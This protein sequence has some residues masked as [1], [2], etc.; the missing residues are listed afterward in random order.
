[1]QESAATAAAPMPVLEGRSLSPSGE[2]TVE[3]TWHDGDSQRRN[4]SPSSVPW[5]AQRPRTHAV[6]VRPDDDDDGDVDELV[7]PSPRFDGGA[8][9]MDVDSQRTLLGENAAGSDVE[10]VAPDASLPGKRKSGVG[11]EKTEH[12]VEVDDRDGQPQTPGK[13]TRMGPHET[14]AVE[15]GEDT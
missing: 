11:P 3:M 1:M 7:E 15:K 2:N 5:H 14:N 4:S 10:S 13:R 8:D 9:A 12:A 6:E